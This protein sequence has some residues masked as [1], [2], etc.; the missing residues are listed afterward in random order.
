MDR[1]IPRLISCRMPK[2]FIATDWTL[3]GIPPKW[4]NPWKQYALR[5]SLQA[6]NFLS[7]SSSSSAHHCALRHTQKPSFIL[8]NAHLCSAQLQ[9]YVS[10]YMQQLV[11]RKVV[12]PKLNCTL[13]CEMRHKNSFVCMT[14]RELNPVPL[15]TVIHSKPFIIAPLHAHSTAYYIKVKCT[16][17]GLAGVVC[18]LRFKVSSKAAS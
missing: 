16:Q 5:I 17:L 9:S 1:F 8:N 15:I 3:N 2:G 12:K 6:C 10:H 13:A 14:H 7:P 18:W 11:W 4:S